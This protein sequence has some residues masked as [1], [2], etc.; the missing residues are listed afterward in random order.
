MNLYIWKIFSTPSH[1]ISLFLFPLSCAAAPSGVHDLA[2]PVFGTK[3]ERGDGR[4]HAA[5]FDFGE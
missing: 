4:R 3:R 1:L 2:L 5:V